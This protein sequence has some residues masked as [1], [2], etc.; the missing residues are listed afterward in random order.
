MNECAGP[1]T[2]RKALNTFEIT[3]GDTTSTCEVKM[4]GERLRGVVSVSFSLTAHNMTTLTLE[5]MG[6]I[7]AKGQFQPECILQVRQPLDGGE[8]WPR[9]ATDDGG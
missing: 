8:C 6:E 2:T 9:R 3:V 5:I 7:I 1:L 4:N